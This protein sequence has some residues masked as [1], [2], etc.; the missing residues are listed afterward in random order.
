[1]SDE[2]EHNHADHE[3]LNLRVVRIP[4]WLTRRE[5]TIGIGDTLTAEDETWPDELVVLEAGAIDVVGR[6]G[7]VVHFDAGAVLTF[8]GV[9]FAEV[10]CASN[11]P[12]VL[13]AVRRHRRH[14]ASD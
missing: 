3:P 14:R 6:C 11:E 9:P 2:R 13:V 12:A 8:E 4:P 1:M 7:R 5:V 10:R